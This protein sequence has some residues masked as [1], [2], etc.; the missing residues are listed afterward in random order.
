MLSDLAALHLAIG[1]IGVTVMPYNLYLHSLLVQSRA[2]PCSL[3]GRRQALRWAVADSNLALT[4]ALLVN[5]MILIVTASVF[6]RNGHTEVVDIEQ[7]HVLLLPLFGLKLASLLFAVALLASDL[8]P[9][10]TTT[11]AG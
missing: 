2:Y 9:T 1:I 4:L 7:T 8:N 10:V 5:A 3:A 11:P 6:H